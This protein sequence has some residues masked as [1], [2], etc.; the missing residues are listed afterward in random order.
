[1]GKKKHTKSFDD[2][3]PIINLIIFGIVFIFIL[4]SLNKSNSNP[5]TR[6]NNTT[7]TTTRTECYIVPTP[8]P[9]DC[10]GNC[11]GHQAGYNWAKK[12]NIM[13]PLACEGNSNSFN[14]GC[15]YYF[16]EMEHKRSIQDCYSDSMYYD[17]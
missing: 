4:L 1:M 13:N 15:E 16:Q 14:A 9:W 11:S 6:E 12:N 10:T 3:I 8:E 5:I 2:Y 7:K 17:E